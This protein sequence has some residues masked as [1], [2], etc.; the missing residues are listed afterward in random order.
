[1]PDRCDIDLGAASD[2]NGN[3]IPDACGEAIYDLDGNGFV[4]F[5]D[6]SLVLLNMGAC[7]APCPYDLSG[8]GWVDS[9][10]L[11]LLLLQFG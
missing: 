7:P 1:M 4:D 5:G 11:S 3:G 10:D 8:D 2:T 9:G 6:V